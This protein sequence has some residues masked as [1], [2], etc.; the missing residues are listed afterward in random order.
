MK[1]TYCKIVGAVGAAAIAL[2][3]CSRPAQAIQTGSSPD[4][5]LGS[6]LSLPTGAAP[7]PGLY[8]RLYPNWAQ[9]YAVNNN[10]ARTG[11]SSTSFG[12][13][14]SF[15]WVPG[16]TV[17]GATYSTAVRGPGILNVQIHK[18]GGAIATT[19]GLV[20]WTV[21][22]FNL[23][24]AL[25]NGLFFDAELGVDVP[26]GSYD[27]ANAANT[28]QNHYALAPNIA[29][30]YLKDGYDLTI[31]ETTETAFQNPSTKYTNGTFSFTDITATKKF[32]KWTTGPV[33][34]VY[35]QI[36]DDS[37]PQKLRSPYPF[38][39]AVGWDLGYD[40]GPATLNGWFVKDVYARN[41]STLA[42]RAQIALSFQIF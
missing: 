6:S 35:S 36:S 2:P 1:S 14:G 10:G 19:T 7:P 37:G 40:L 38:E 27:S 16:F 29:L 3:L 20:D 9:S 42:I 39:A 18:P 8:V 23:S 22:P 4:Y 31:H 24:W 26:I 13:F 5:P 33:G 17:L 28:A 11:V 34:F 15:T 30:T 21:V 12:D 41:V 32:G 25:G